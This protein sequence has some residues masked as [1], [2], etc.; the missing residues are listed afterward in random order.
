MKRYSLLILLLLCFELISAQGLFLDKNYSG[1][2]IGTVIDGQNDKSYLGQFKAGFSYYGIMDVSLETGL[3]KANRNVDAQGTGFHYYSITPTITVH[4][5]RQDERIP[6]SISLFASSRSDNYN[7]DYLDNNYIT[8]YGDVLSAGV[9]ATKRFAVS[10][11]IN[12]YPSIGLIYIRES[13][14][15]Y[16]YWDDLISK[17]TSNQGMFKIGCD[18]TFRIRDNRMIAANVNVHSSQ[19]TIVF[20]ASIGIILQSKLR[21][22]A[23]RYLVPM[24]F[25]EPEPQQAIVFEKQDSSSIIINIPNSRG[26]YNPVKLVKTEKGYVGPQ[27]ELYAENPTVEQLKVLYGN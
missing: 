24:M 20:S 21:Y 15:A 19:N 6:L 26:G 13:D 11:K 4:A 23:F 2:E 9:S 3:G 22:P 7:S 16:D 18:A 14:W 17:S 27:G 12:L 25:T 1:L 10:P 5:L 8:L